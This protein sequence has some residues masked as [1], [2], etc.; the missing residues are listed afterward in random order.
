M[1]EEAAVEKIPVKAAK[2]PV[3]PATDKTKPAV[4]QK[5]ESKVPKVETKEVA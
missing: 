3:M 2:K 5:A 1:E 4:K